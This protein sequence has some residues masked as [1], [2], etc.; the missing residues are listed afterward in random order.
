MIKPNFLYIAT[1]ATALVVVGTGVYHL[2]RTGSPSAD[3]VA[4]AQM[5]HP[6]I[7][8]S[9]FAPGDVKTVILNNIPVI[10][11]RRND[12]DKRLAASQNDPSDWVYKHTM[13]YGQPN[14]VFAD[15]ANLTI[16]DEWIVVL[17][18]SGDWSGFENFP[19]VRYGDFDGFWEGHY[20]S[21]FDLSGRY[22]QGYPKRNMIVVQ[23]KLI[24]DQRQLQL[25]MSVSPRIHD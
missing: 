2:I 1:A 8:V 17:A 20:V 13:I 5:A 15:D 4:A 10:V 6:T 16:N 12:A 9:D 18:R 25:N 24:N 23:G 22:R 11:W 19:L 14:A 3:V 21:H 7:N